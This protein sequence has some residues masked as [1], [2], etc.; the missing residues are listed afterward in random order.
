MSLLDCWV[1]CD[2]RQGLCTEH[3]VES[4]RATRLAVWRGIYPCGDGGYCAGRIG[5]HRFRVPGTFDVWRR[6]GITDSTVVRRA[7]YVGLFRRGGKRWVKVQAS[8]CAPVWLQR[9][10]EEIVTEVWVY[11]RLSLAQAL[12]LIEGFD[13]GTLRPYW[14]KP[15]DEDEL[16]CECDSSRVCYDSASEEEEEDF[17]DY[18]EEYEP[19][20]WDEEDWEDE[21]Y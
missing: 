19:I 6:D 2:D 16:P 13:W 1:N 8:R 12:E 5:E 18:G 20:D 7:V 9:A 14:E 4:Y 3:A 10:V 17:D 15:G 11:R 21:E